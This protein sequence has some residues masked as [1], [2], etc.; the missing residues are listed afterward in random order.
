MS[1]AMYSRLWQ[2]FLDTAQMVG[3]SAL[4]ALIAGIP[5][6]I[7]LVVSAPGGF[8]AAPRLN[9]AVAVDSSTSWLSWKLRD[10]LP[11]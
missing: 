8:F 1:P 10:T 7:F 2:A 9:R 3:I 6:A 11:K 4:I 5:I